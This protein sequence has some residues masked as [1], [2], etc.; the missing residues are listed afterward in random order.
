MLTK[1]LLVVA[2]PLEAIDRFIAL[3]LVSSASSTITLFT[4]Y[5]E[6]HHSSA[7][8]TV[9]PTDFIGHSLRETTT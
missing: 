4:G 3:W 6:L 5:S 2:K 8:T 7:I 9:R 1:L